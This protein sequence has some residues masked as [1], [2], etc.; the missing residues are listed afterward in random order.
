MKYGAW[1]QNKISY[2]GR[3]R[4]IEANSSGEAHKI[5]EKKKNKNEWYCWMMP[6]KDFQKTFLS[7]EK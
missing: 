7:K 6:W 4:I 1:Y 5:S 2:R 3:Y